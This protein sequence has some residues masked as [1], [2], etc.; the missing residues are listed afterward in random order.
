MSAGE[1]EPF[2]AA[3]LAR[4]PEMAVAAAFCPAGQRTRFRAWGALCHQL[5]ETLFE[6][7]DPRV[8]AAKT[9]WWAEELAGWAR[10]ASRHPLAQELLPV[11]ADWAGLGRALLAA[12]MDEARAAEAEQALRSFDAWSLA[13]ARVE[14]A[15]FD[16]PAPGDLRPWNVHWLLHRLPHGLATDDGARVPLQLLARH[17][18][19]RQALQA[20][21][22]TALLAE[23]SGWLRTQL[24]APAADWP[25]YRR[26]RAAQDG[27]RLERIAAGRGFGAPP[28]LAGLWRSWRAARLRPA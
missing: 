21:G 16:A 10:G 4:E 11:A 3:W 25:I 12:G 19:S 13:V 9:A 6:L 24:P 23:W 18:L 20:G 15:L 14:C 1:V 2:V 7:S 22:G 17:Q 26:L 8:S 27:L 28:A 5:R